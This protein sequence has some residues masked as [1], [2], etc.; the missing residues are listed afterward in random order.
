[1]YVSPL[2]GFAS[3]VARTNVPAESRK[4]NHL[5]FY[6]AQR[7]IQGKFVGFVG[8]GRTPSGRV[9]WLK[10]LELHGCIKVVQ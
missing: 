4:S 7:R 8:F 6:L 9:W 5:G 2:F 3:K 10:T 1:M